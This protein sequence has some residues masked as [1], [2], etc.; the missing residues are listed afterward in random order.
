[1]G[2]LKNIPRRVMISGSS[3]WDNMRD[4]RLL[5]PSL[6]Q[7]SFDKIASD[8]NIRARS[9]RVRLNVDASFRVE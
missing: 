9:R 4:L 2:I 5:I 3:T 8:C 7:N 1:M 6:E